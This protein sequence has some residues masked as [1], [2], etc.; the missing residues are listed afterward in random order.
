LR[1]PDQAAFCFDDQWWEGI[2]FSH[3]GADPNMS[4]RRSGATANNAGWVF[5]GYA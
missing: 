5:V 2:G 1:P 3:A 4:M